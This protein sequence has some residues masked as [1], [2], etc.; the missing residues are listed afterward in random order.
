[1]ARTIG[2][3]NKPKPVEEGVFEYTLEQRL[4]IVADLVVER[5][6]EDQSFGQKIVDILGIGANDVTERK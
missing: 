6:I 4:K 1:M 5:I 2:S 3:K